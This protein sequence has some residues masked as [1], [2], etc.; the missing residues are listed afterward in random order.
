[1]VAAVGVWARAR[2][3]MAER[4]RWLVDWSRTS[5]GNRLLTLLALALGVRLV[6]A[7]FH[8]FFHDLQAYVTWG[9]LL[10]H[11]FFHFYTVAASTNVPTYLPNYPPLTV[12]LYGLLDGAYIAVAHLFTPQPTLS[13][14]ASPL[15]AVYMKLPVC[16]ADL[17]LV[18][19]I[20]TQARRLR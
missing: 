5:D 4:L 3:W 7:P 8:G 6:L 20:Y 1:M 10:D 13:V 18:G 16:A 9:Q 14:A 11:D 12:Y 17:A 19:I 15:L 2:V